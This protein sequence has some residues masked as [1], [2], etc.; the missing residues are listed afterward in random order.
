[1]LPSAS[2]SKT[3]EVPDV[4]KKSKSEAISEL[5]KLKFDLKCSDGKEFATI[6]S[7]TIE[8]GYVVKT[9]PYAGTTVKE[10][11]SV[12]IYVSSGEAS[13]EL[14]DYALQNIKEV[15]GILSLK[16]SEVGCSVREDK[17][18]V[19]ES[20]KDKYSDIQTIVK[21]EPEA[22]TVIKKN[23]EIVLYAPDIEIN[24]PDFSTYTK[25]QID[26]FAKKNEIT[27]IYNEVENSLLPPG[28]VTNQSR[29]KGTVVTKGAS[30][31]I[32]ITK[33]PQVVDDIILPSEDDSTNEGDTDE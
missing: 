3:L 21:T 14:D 22:G 24:Y 13:F 25:A 28:T 26:D 29:A 10:G 33:A 23:T 17:V 31:T 18:K 27:V 20:E 6:S 16:C 2:K 5:T 19:S 4:S 32:T 9:D 1:M 15:K 12:C 11:K 7:E 8:E 30:I